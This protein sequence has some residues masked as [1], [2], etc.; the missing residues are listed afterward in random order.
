MDS[1][2]WIEWK[3]PLYLL[4]NKDT[5]VLITSTLDMLKR[6]EQVSE[7]N[8]LPDDEYGRNV[9]YEILIDS[10]RV[11]NIAGLLDKTLI[12]CSHEI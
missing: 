9:K 8:K 10:D 5:E 6:D 4:L 7:V 1:K 3:I 11:E 2:T 12:L